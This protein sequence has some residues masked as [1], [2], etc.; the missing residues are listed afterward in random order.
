MDTLVLEDFILHK[1]RQ[2]EENRRDE[3]DYKAQ[4]ALD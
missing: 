2:P 3:G 4:F 1:E